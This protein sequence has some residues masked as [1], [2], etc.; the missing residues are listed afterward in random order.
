MFGR[1]VLYPWGMETDQSTDATQTFLNPAYDRSRDGLLGT[2][3][4]EYLPNRA[5]DA[6]GELLSELQDLANATTAEI[7][8][9]A[10]SNSTAVS[11][12]DLHR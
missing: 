9:S 1:T 5:A 7:I 11:P 3:Y 2:S 6:R 4:G 8:T 10:G 12:L